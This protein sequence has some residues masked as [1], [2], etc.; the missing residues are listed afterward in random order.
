MVTFIGEYKCRVD[1]KGRLV[2]PAPFKNA[3][4]EGGDMRF[5]IKKSLYSNCLDMYTYEEWESQS[6]K[7]QDSL[8]FFN[9]DHSKFWEQYMRDRD[10]VEPD[11]KLGRISISHNLL[12]A[13]GIDKEVVFF[14]V[15]FKIEI[16]AKEAFEASRLSNQD[17]IAI[18][19]SLSR[20]R[21]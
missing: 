2:F 4:P 14:G 7:V 5:V 3:M 18:A 17:F 13:I 19:R 6:G 11:A 10:V 8:D 20:N 15:D 9:P 1:D 21:E 16:W 12:D